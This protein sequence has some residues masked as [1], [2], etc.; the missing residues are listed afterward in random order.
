M[1]GNIRVLIG[2]ICTVVVF[3]LLLVAVST[4]SMAV[5]ERFREL[6][7]L[8]ALVSTGASFCVYSRGK[9]WLAMMGALFERAGL[10]VF[11]SI[12]ISKV[13]NGIFIY[14]E[15]TPKIMG[16][17]FLVASALG[18]VAAI[19]SAWRWRDERR[20]RGFKTLD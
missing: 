5:R 18:I 15:V 14:F 16:Q 4:V 20:G 17:A 10:G 11:H 3:T 1:W 13:S 2:S 7:V 19:A 12:D 6:A 9:F 8:E